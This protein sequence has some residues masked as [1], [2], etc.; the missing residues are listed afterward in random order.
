MSEQAKTLLEQ[1][2]V[3]LD[4]LKREIDEL[5]A[6]FVEVSRPKLVLID[7]GRDA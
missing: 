6:S 7:G 3:E 4:E 5:G 2:L 1:I